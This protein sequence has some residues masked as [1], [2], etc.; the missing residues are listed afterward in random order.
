MFLETSKNTPTEWDIVR[1]LKSLLNKP[2]ILINLA[3]TPGFFRSYFFQHF[4]FLQGVDPNIGKPGFLSFH[5][6]TWVFLMREDLDCL[7]RYKSEEHDEMEKSKSRV[8]VMP[9][10]KQEAQHKKIDFFQFSRRELLKMFDRWLILAF[11]FSQH[12]VRHQ[13]ENSLLSTCS[14]QRSSQKQMLCPYFFQPRVSLTSHQCM[15]E[16]SIQGN[17]VDSMLIVLIKKS[18]L[19]SS[20]IQYLGQDQTGNASTL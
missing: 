2:E 4:K 1:N 10:D 9:Q 20:W 18:S 13:L 12:S 6:F 8:N 15:D 14:R 17:C 3:L 7:S 19:N 11:S 16:L 5:I